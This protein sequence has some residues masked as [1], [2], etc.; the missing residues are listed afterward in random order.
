MHGGDACR[1]AVEVDTGKVPAV[2]DDAEMAWLRAYLTRTKG[3]RAGSGFVNHIPGEWA[4]V[5]DD[6]P[7]AVAETA[8]VPGD[9]PGVTNARVQSGLP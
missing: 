6:E 9:L 1:I 5:D 2:E 4:D 8:V 7:E 3:E